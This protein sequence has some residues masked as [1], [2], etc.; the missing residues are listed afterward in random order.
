[1]ALYYVLPPQCWQRFLLSVC[2]YVCLP[3][4]VCLS[5]TILAHLFSVLLFSDEDTDV[6]A[7]VQTWLNKLPESQ[8]DKVSGWIE[9]HFYKGLDLVLKQVQIIY[10]VVEPHDWYKLFLCV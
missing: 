9:D 2:L 6:K 4:Y 3:V 10:Q 5:Q 7:I 8:R 1:M